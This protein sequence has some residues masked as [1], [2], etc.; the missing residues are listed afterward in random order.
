MPK[1]SQPRGF[2]LP[3]PKKIRAEL[4]RRIKSQHQGLKLNELP[5][6]IWRQVCYYRKQYY[7]LMNIKAVGEQLC[8]DFPFTELI[9]PQAESVVADAAMV[10]WLTTDEERFTREDFLN[11]I[12]VPTLSY[13]LYETYP[14]AILAGARSIRK[15]FLPPRGVD[16]TTFDVSAW[17]DAVDTVALTHKI[18][19]EEVWE[20]LKTKR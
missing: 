19:R 5:G 9:V 4:L 14:E 16:K 11:N 17:F 20:R 12:D 3:E 1:K 2:E 10:A 15:Y 8:E 13:G 6:D 7:M 18:T